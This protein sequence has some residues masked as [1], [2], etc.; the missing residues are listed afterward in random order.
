MTTAAVLLAALAPAAP[1]PPDPWA[2]QKVLPAAPGLALRDAD[3]KDIGAWTVCVGVVLR[4]DGEWVEV[5]HKQDPGPYRGWVKKAEVVKLADAPAHFTRLLAADDPTW[6]Y[7]N[8]A[9]AWLHTGRPEKAVE[10]LSEVVK[11]RPGPSAFNSRGVARAEAG[12][13]PGAAA[14]YAAALAGDPDGGYVLNNLAW[15]LAT[16]PDDKV[17]DGKRAVELATKACERTGWKLANNVD[18]LAAAHAE[19]GDFEQAVKYQKQAL[20]DRAF[21]A[22]AGAAARDRVKLYA[23]GKP[24]REAPPAKKD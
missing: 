19:A 5:Y 23:A 11:R 2:G 18:T 16:C 13:Y 9:E 20:D 17:R 7:T 3:R 14:D 8:R 6:A 24:Y 15:L 21:A 22:T 1:V 4:A 12:D 10:D